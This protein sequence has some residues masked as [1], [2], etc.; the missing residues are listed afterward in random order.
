MKR[1]N[2]HQPFEISFSELDES[3][4]Q[5]HD[6][7]FFELVYILSGTGVQW[8][9]NN[10]FLY[11]DG[12]LFMITPG[13]TH[14]FDI[15]TTTKFVYIKF[16]DIYIHSAVLG[17]E[18]IRRLEFILQ[19]ANHRPGCILRNQTD[20]LLVK[21]MIEAII[22]EYVNRNIYSS[23]IITQL[24]NTIVIIVA[25]NIA[26]FLPEQIDENS[27]DKSLNI[28]QYIQSNICFPEK[29]KARTISQHFGISPNYLGRYFKKQ[30]NETMQQ[31]I[32]NYK[33][34]MV[35]SRLL[36]SEMRINEIVEELGFTDES[37][38]NKLFK[39][40]KG[41]NPTDFR[42]KHRG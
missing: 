4:L 21:P 22:R 5:E 11:H 35:E 15:H 27:E 38:L 23:E 24:I 30:T 9:N 31:Y 12:H 37:H 32:F 26:L 34:K 36:H 19:H 16:N 20:K 18:N 6:H 10:K 3:Q 13:D 8:I 25:R 17:T 14:S 2:L 29:I 33:M 28:L 39:K 40:Y 42:K 7:T 41:C 1:E